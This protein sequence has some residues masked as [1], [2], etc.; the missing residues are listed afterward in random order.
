MRRMPAVPPHRMGPAGRGGAV[1]PACMVKKSVIA[2]PLS[3]FSETKALPASIVAP[4]PEAHNAP[5]FDGGTA[6]ELL[7]S[8]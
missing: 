2:G 6:A 5:E 7:G 8:A 3:S 1:S 4:G